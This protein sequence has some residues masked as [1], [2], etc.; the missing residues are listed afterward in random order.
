MEV[1]LHITITTVT[2]ITI[3]TKDD[4]KDEHLFSFSNRFRQPRAASFHNMAACAPV[5][6]STSQEK[7]SE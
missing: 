7:E 2:I 6:M 3:P 5:I 4:K 1:Q